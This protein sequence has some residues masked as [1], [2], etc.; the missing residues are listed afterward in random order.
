M[1]ERDQIDEAG[2]ERLIP[3][4]YE[5]VRA[6]PE[7]GPIFNEAVADWPGHLE[8]LIAFW[9]SVMLTTGR[10]KGSPLADWTDRDVWLYRKKHDLPYHPLW[11]EGYVSI[12]DFHTTSRWEPGMREEDTRFFGLKRECGIHVEI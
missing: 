3:L 6:D 10:Y 12:G 7:I 8:R 2:L 9:S 5:R 1:I 4:F 11:D